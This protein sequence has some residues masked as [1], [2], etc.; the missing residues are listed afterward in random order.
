M[1]KMTGL[2]L[3]LS[4]VYGVA[5][6]QPLSP[7]D[8]QQWLLEQVRI[9]EA[10]YREDLVH[11]SLA[12]LELI[13]PDN[14]QVKVVEV[15]QALLH[16]NQPEAERLVAQLRQ[17]APGTAALRQA[18]S[19]LK[20]H[21]ADGQRALQ[22][23]RLL[24]VAGRSEDAVKAYRQLFGDDMPDFATALEYLNVRS[25][26]KAE[27]PVV[28]EQLR[29]LDR[30]YPGNASLRQ[31][32][33]GLL[34]AEKRD[35][36]ALDV[37][38]QLAG[39]PNASNNAAEREYNY[40]LKQPVGHETAQGWQAFLKLY[41]NTSLRADATKQLQEQEQYLADPAWQAGVKGKA[42][43]EAGD[44]VGAEASL[45]RAIKRYPQDSSLV[46]SLGVSLMRQNK[47]EAA[48][49]AFVKA[50]SIEQDTFWITKWQDLKA[51]NYQWMLL[52]KGDE[53]LERKD[54]PVAKKWY[55]QA[56]QAKPDD[57]ASLIGLSYAA[58]GESDDISAEALLVRARKLDPNNASVVR[59]M[60]RL[61]QSQSPEKAE[62]YLDSLTPKE[63][64]EFQG[65]RRGLALDRL[66]AQADDAT[67][68]SDWAQVTAALSKARVLD[69]DNP[70]LVYRLAN[71]Q[72]ELGLNTEADQSFHWLLQ[73]QGQNTE[74]RY[75][76]A[77]FLANA[78]RDGDAM[79]SLQQIPRAAWSDNMNELWA[80][81]QR[82][83]MLAKARAL[84]DGGRE[85][86]AEALLMRAPTTDDYLTLA[87][88]A[89]QRGDLVQAES[90]YRKVLSS[91]P[92]NAEAQLGL[93]E[94]LIARGQPNAAKV[95]LMA[96]TAP[97][98]A[99]VP[100]QRRLANAWASLGD[101]TRANALFAQLLNTPQSDPLVYR[102]AARLLSREEPQRALDDY[103]RSMGAARMIDPPQAEPRDNRAMT[104]ASRATDSDDWLKR[105][106]RS[107]VDELYQKQNPTVNLYHDLAWRTDNSSSGVSDLTTQTTIL[108]IDAPVAQGQ[109][110]V[111]A[112]DI[113]LDVSNFS[114]SDRFGLC[115]VVQGGCTSA[116]QSVHGT[117]LGMGWHDDRWAF[118][119]GHT[120]QE[121][122]VSNWVGG[123][124]YSGD[125]SSVGYR[126]TAS[127]RP[128][129]NSL[130]SYA[131]AVDPVTGTKWGGVTANGF[132]LG[133]S[134]DQGG[135]DGVW[136]SLSSHWLVGQNVE[137]NQRR[138]AMGGYYY[139]L[140]ERADERL[141][142]GLTLMYMGYDKDLSE[143][144]LGQG[145][146]YSPQQ[147][148]SVS[149]PVNY[150]WRNA[151]W[152][153]LLESSV[154]WSFAK[155]DGSDLYP[156][157]NREADLQS[158]LAQSNKTLVDNPS[159]TKSGSSSNGFNFRVQGLV[160]RRLSDN[161]V[162]GTGITWQHSEGYAP[163]R[164]LIYL[165][166][167]FDPW[168]G[169]LPL[170]VTPISPYADMR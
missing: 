26:I 156:K 94:V 120:P 154:G 77:L 3:L 37:L 18:E 106:I 105:S 168:Q 109:G 56:N 170:P 164:A 31:T 67:R 90:R 121:F 141:R 62:H 64:Q 1:H 33:A 128:L 2:G 110:F 10:L 117:L 79:G 68:R 42:L 53:A 46:G 145:G 85:A 78:E 140:V 25:G 136:A 165:R 124:T 59:A 74:A 12:R 19:L 122:T 162:L 103:A 54:Y 137:N 126:L 45:L 95:S 150:A 35:P 22:E 29:E 144:T 14:P 115:A 166:Y 15:R 27:R 23:A 101:K 76:H 97:V 40:W 38:H 5:L 88:W 98:P 127:R 138:T 28:I 86:Q 131:G 63:Q 51:A 58:R 100:F 116:S 92:K 99:D 16:K 129:T 87:D 108:R 36:E 80:R 135:K 57:P 155:I 8:Q 142:T 107:D 48:Y 159:M 52:Q 134:H 96:V 114:S 72:R 146:Y 160:E 84:R 125:W 20:M 47:H 82:R 119:L 91:A 153:A 50:S 89:Q 65:V 4:S 61:Y 147:Y 13:A 30:Q 17:Q 7:P 151:D 21:G 123:V 43:L 81:L 102:D 11:D 158:L 93:S 73:R 6:G 169:N 83:Q 34:F 9:G 163:S 139:R 118:D 75:A 132:T 130:V 161:L 111:Q 49:N 133:L 24:A 44:N 157:D 104:L 69:P 143:D 112:E 55:R 41:P 39:D 66:N 60:V 70:W 152:S 71:A 149:V 148:Y 32:M 167:T 113:N